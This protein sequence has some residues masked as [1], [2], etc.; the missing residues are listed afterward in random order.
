[1]NNPPIGQPPSLPTL[2]GEVV[3]TLRTLPLLVPDNQPVGCGLAERPEIQAPLGKTANGFDAMPGSGPFVSQASRENCLPP[4]PATTD[5]SHTAPPLLALILHHDIDFRVRLPKYGGKEILGDQTRRTLAAHTRPSR[6]TLAGPR[7]ADL[8]KDFQAFSHFRLLPD[9][10]PPKQKATPSPHV[11][12]TMQPRPLVQADS[13][14]CVPQNPPDSRPDV[15]RF[16][17]SFS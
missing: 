11:E 8:Q 16:P 5:G 3:S 6:N 17:L 7:D 2:I 4:P 15:D 9:R 14:Y 13:R 1:M 10:S 12:L